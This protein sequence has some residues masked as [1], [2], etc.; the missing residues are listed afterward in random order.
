MR[1]MSK[2]LSIQW[3]GCILC[4]I[5]NKCATALD[6]K[7]PIKIRCSLICLIKFRRFKEYLQKSEV[8]ESIN[9]EMHR[10]LKLCF[11]VGILVSECVESTSLLFLNQPRCSKMQFHQ[12]LL[13]DVSLSNRHFDFKHSAQ[14]TYWKTSD[15]FAR[16]QTKHVFEVIR[17]KKHNRHTMPRAK[18]TAPKKKEAVLKRK[19]A[20]PKKKTAGGSLK[21]R[22]EAMW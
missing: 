19:T 9:S 1:W 21:L 16:H 4:V 20:T 2:I 6:W 8:S 22:H 14:Q 11:V 3:N 18:K 10:V 15:V 5:V 17:R 12:F 7:I 13:G